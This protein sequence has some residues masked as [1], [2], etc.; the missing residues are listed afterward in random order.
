VKS[1]LKSVLERKRREVEAKQTASVPM[2]SIYDAFTRCSPHL[3]HPEHLHPYCQAWN[4]MVQKRQEDEAVEIVFHAPPQHGKTTIGAH[5]FIYAAVHDGATRG[6][7][8]RRHAY[9][10]YNEDKAIGVLKDVQQ[11]A[12][13]A[14]L[15]PHARKRDLYL[16]G[17]TIVRFVGCVSG[18][19]TGHPVDGIL[20][21]DDPIKDRKEACSAVTREDR[22]AWFTDVAQTRRHPGSSVVVMHTRWHP[23]DLAGRILQRMKWPYIRLSAICDDADDLLGRQIGEALWPAHRPAEWLAQFMVN[24]LTWTSMYQGS[25]RPLG[26]AL[27]TDAHYYDKLPDTSYRVGYGCDL[28]YSGKTRSDWSTLL[29]A[30]KYGPDIYLRT[31]IRKQIQADRFTQLMK[32]RIQNELG[33]CLWFGASTE[34]GTASLIREQI[35]SFRFAMAA[36][37]KYTR[38]LPTAEKLWNPGKILVP[39]PQIFHSAA[40]WVDDFIHEVALFTGMDDPQDDQVDALAALGHLFLKGYGA[41]SGVDPLNKALVAGIRPH[42]RLAI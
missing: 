26:D 38:A 28:A 3:V 9:A 29:G 8:G 17:G 18:Q 1:G 40:G 27:F 35:P 42:L 22:W 25:P 7:H 12:F 31:M 32:A 5:G 21:I 14:G 6:G 11:L 34:R 37:D 41:G 33:P 36:A 39:N 19:L 13:I 16:S 10:T 15:D 30:R 2:T 20:L 23:D 24:V 4:I